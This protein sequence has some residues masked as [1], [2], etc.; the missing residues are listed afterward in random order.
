[1][2]FWIDIDVKGDGRGHF[3]GKSWLKDR[4]G[5]GNQLTFEISFDQTELATI[6]RSLRGALEMFP[7]VGQPTAE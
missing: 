2:E 4:P 1:M 5:M 7:V 6:L 3:V